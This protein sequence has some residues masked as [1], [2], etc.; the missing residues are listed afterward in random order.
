M[1]GNFCTQAKYI[2]NGIKV[3]NKKNEKK[4]NQLKTDVDKAKNDYS[5]MI[6]N[7]YKSRLRESRLMFLLSSENFLQA[8]KRTQ[9]MNQYS[10]NRRSY[11]NKIESNI[12]K[13]KLINDTIIKM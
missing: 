5:K 13:I 3:I 11:A 8:L 4:V 10:N 1:I 7:S 6:Y 12:E 9:Y 2:R